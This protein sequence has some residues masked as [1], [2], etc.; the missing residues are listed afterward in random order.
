ME[1][2]L[3]PEVPFKYKGPGKPILV[4]SDW[5]FIMSPFVGLALLWR[6]ERCQWRRLIPLGAFK[7]VQ[8]KRLQ[9]FNP[10]CCG[11]TQKFKT[12]SVIGYKWG[13]IQSHDSAPN[14][15]SCL[16]ISRLEDMSNGIKVIWFIWRGRWSGSKSPRLKCLLIRGTGNTIAVC[17]AK[18]NCVIEGATK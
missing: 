7:I 2:L 17:E 18:F 12:P 15:L 4:Q 8:K 3:V 9:T 5:P 10:V 1:N 14:C 16:I 13:L 6:E 11:F